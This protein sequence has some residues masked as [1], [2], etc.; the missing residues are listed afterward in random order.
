[1]IEILL[2]GYLHKTNV[3]YKQTND[4]DMHDVQMKHNTCEFTLS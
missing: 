2:E 3:W 4:E 1:M